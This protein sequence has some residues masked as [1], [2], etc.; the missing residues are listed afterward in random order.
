MLLRNAKQILHIVTA[1]FSAS[2][3]DE[4]RSVSSC[5]DSSIDSIDNLGCEWVS[6]LQRLKQVQ[7]DSDEGLEELLIALAK[8]ILKHFRQVHYY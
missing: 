5:P 4:S 3:F 1:T 7:T 8:V 6:V 2:L